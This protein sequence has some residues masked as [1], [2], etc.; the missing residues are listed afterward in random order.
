MRARSGPLAHRVTFVVAVVVAALAVITGCGVP[1]DDEPRAI[2]A[3]STTTPPAASSSGPA[4]GQTEIYLSTPTNAA[5]ESEAQLEAVSRNMGAQPNP[6]NVLEALLEGPT[7][8]EQNRDLLTL[9]P[10]GTTVLG[11][12]LDGNELT[13]ELGDEWDSLSGPDE[14]GAYAQIVLSM[15]NLDSVTRVR[16]KVDGKSVD[17][18]PTGGDPQ[19]V[20]TR[21]DYLDMISPSG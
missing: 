1:T 20:V 16:F 13:V 21:A 5:T 12:T 4:S 19:P 18:V 11:T 9:I 15:T 2:T 7:A 10:P 8:E 3:E 14:L 6:D 17:D